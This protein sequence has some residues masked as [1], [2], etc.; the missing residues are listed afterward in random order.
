MRR[1]RSGLADR[2]A[3]SD[4][5][6]PRS[7]H[8]A[9]TRP[10]ALGLSLPPIETECASLGPDRV[11]PRIPTSGSDPGRTGSALGV[12]SDLIDFSCSREFCPAA[13]ARAH[14]L[15]PI[16][17]THTIA[18]P[19]PNDTQANP[20]TCPAQRPAWPRSRQPTTKSGRTTKNVSCT[21]CTPRRLPTRTET[22][23]GTSRG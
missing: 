18:E 20:A 5:A 1:G 14:S 2:A 17:S 15:S 23:W 4:R 13:I 10:T 11:L 19:S 12:L 6:G 9:T 16:R 21:R 7:P 8:P 22:A 3:A